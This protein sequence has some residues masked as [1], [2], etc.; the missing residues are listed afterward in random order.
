[1]NLISTEDFGKIV[2]KI[3]KVLTAERVE[4]SD[5]L[6]KLQVDTGEVRQ[7][8]AGI[9]KSYTP[10]ELIDKKI[11]VV[12]NLRPAK[13]MGIESLGML[14]AAD[15]NGTLSI[16]IPDKEIKEGEVIK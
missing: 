9:G 3:G 1:M 8:V 4:G 15:T 13:I 2:L 16:L 10:E 14:L 12:A 6:I 7:I 11:A 5:K